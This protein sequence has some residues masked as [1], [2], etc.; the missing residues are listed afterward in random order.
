ML[1]SLSHHCLQQKDK[2]AVCLSSTAP[3]SS[4]SPPSLVFWPG[5][6][7]SCCP[8]GS[9][10][11]C[12]Y[13]SKWARGHST[14]PGITLKVAGMQ[15]R[16]GCWFGWRLQPQIKQ[17]PSRGPADGWTGVLS[18][19]LYIGSV[20]HSLGRVGEKW[21]ALLLSITTE[22]QMATPHPSPT[23]CSKTPHFSIV[24]A[25]GLR[26]QDSSTVDSVVEC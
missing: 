22:L 1:L 12:F 19:G 11:R 2:R 15:S 13:C 26:A 9:H 21:A 17:I 16:W 25:D 18:P 6:F 5:F 7:H 20:A 3:S 14:L 8:W 23:S 4:Q 10:S 24:A